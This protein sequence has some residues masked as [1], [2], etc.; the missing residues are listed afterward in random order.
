M[1]RASAVRC[2]CGGPRGFGAPRAKLTGRAIGAAVDALRHDDTTVSALA[3][4]LGV[5]WDTRIDTVAHAGSTLS[6]IR[7]TLLTGAEHL[8]ERQRAR[9]EKLP[10]RDPSGEVELARRS[11]SRPRH[12]PRTQPDRRP[13]R[14]RQAPRHLEDP[15]RRRSRPARPDAAAVAP[16]DPGRRR[17]RWSQQRRHRS[18]LR[19]G[20]PTLSPV[21]RW[22]AHR[23][24][25]SSPVP[26]R[27]SAS[28]SVGRSVSRPEP[29]APLRTGPARSPAAAP[30]R[31]KHG[32]ASAACL[33][34]GSTWS[35]STAR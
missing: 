2:E 8:T 35:G 11:A 33:S 31:S 14:S 7:Q 4:R 21:L 27:Q 28:R 29:A 15:P 34:A 3:R 1:R 13:P 25:R 17:H 32:T 23:S 9:L 5:A 16:A 10:L 19:R 30:R 20:E 24:R 6:R 26:S 12:V 22:R 18:L